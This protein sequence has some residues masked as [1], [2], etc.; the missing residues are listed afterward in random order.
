MVDVT[1][2]RIGSY[3]NYEQT[4]H[5]VCGISDDNSIESYWVNKGVVDKSFRY[6]DNCRNYKLIPLTKE[7]LLELGAE[8][9]KDKN[10]FHF[11]NFIY[12]KLEDDDWTE[13]AFNVTMRATYIT[14]ISFVNELQNL[15]N[16]IEFDELTIKK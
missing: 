9:I 15:Y 5:V 3:L 10:E 13:P 16:S 12:L 11:D 8:Q 2:I 1:E 7:T 4:T 6:K 14:C